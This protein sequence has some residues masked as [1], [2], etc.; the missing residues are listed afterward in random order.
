VFSDLDRRRRQAILREHLQYANGRRVLELGSHC[1]IRWIEELGISPRELECINISEREI[2][3][4]AVVAKSSRVKPAFSLMDANDLRFP[5][6]GFDMVFGNAILHHLEFEKALGEVARVLKPG[7]R[8][9]FGEP[10][11]VNPVGK[12]VR[13]LT[14]R[15]RTPDERP[16]RSKEIAQIRARFETSI[17]YEQLFSMPV[18]AV[19]NALGARPDN[20]FVRS[21]FNLD[22]FIEARMPAV[23]ILYRNVLISGT[24]RGVHSNG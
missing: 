9:F 8:I 22:R 16:L 21:A 12:L 6:E 2:E 17:F 1:W 20:W 18:A 10:L 5:D 24:K 14:P 3:K 15:A 19:S 7:G 23:R 11:G 13:L 4:G